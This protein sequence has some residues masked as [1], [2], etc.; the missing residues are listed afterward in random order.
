[1][2]GQGAGYDTKYVV[3]ASHVAGTYRAGVGA[4]GGAAV[5]TPACDA[6]SRAVNASGGCGLANR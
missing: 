2:A 1:M 4:G 3:T 5:G 6:A